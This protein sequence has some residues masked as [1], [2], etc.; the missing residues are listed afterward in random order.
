MRK[1]RNKIY[2]NLIF[3]FHIY[4]N[5]LVYKYI[6]KLTFT[7]EVLYIKGRTV[8]DSPKQYRAKL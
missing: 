4:K 2:K 5:I 3:F 8:I 1:T 7:E 6:N